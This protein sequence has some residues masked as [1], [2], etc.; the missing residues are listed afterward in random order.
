MVSIVLRQLEPGVYARAAYVAG[1]YTS[2]NCLTP[3]RITV[4]EV[5]FRCGDWLICKVSPWALAELMSR[6]DNVELGV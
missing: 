1:V 3:E 2:G 6:T 5:K 4:H